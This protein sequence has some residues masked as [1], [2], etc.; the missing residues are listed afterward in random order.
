MADQVIVDGNRFIGS[1]F[2]SAVNDEQRTKLYD[3]TTEVGKMDGRKKGTTLEFCFTLV[4]S[5]PGGSPML[6]ALENYEV[7]EN[8]FPHTSWK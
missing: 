8:R 7:A 6:P 3:Y 1:K 4:K 5:L 2:P